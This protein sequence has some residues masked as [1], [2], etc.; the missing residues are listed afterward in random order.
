MLELIVLG[1]I[2]GTG[3]VVDFQAV[4]AVATIIAGVALLRYIRKNRLI[5]QLVQIEEITL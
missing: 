4:A 1:K 3:I 2:P 5:E